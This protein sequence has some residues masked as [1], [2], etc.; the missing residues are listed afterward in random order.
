MVGCLSDAYEVP[1]NTRI[2]IIA[3]ENHRNTHVGC[4]LNRLTQHVT[5]LEEKI[6]EWKGKEKKGEGREER[7]EK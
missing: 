4:T 5:R 6:G 1:R 2:S 3:M 7:R